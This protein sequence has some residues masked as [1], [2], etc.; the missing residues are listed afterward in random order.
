MSRLEFRVR[1]KKTKK[2][3]CCYQNSLRFTLDT[4][5][6]YTAGSINVTD[7]YYIE[8]YTGLK[9]KNG[10]KVFEGDIVKCGD[11][12]TGV[13]EYSKNDY[14]FLYEQN[15]GYSHLLTF[16]AGYKQFEIIGNIHQNPELLK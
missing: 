1:S 9:D 8:Q 3:V 14:G 11:S 12:H 16:L 13:V 10:K 5:Q 6:L 7:S 4:G 2:L 15:S